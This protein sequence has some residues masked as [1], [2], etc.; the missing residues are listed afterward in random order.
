MY[1]P[2]AGLCKGGRLAL[3]PSRSSGYLKPHIVTPTVGRGL[4]RWAGK[5]G[6]ASAEGRGTVRLAWEK[7]MERAYSTHVVNLGSGA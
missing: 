2:R 6:R 4:E 7:G 1:A 3:T 5:K